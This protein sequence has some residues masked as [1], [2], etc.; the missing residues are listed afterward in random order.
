MRRFW[1]STSVFLSVFL[2]LCCAAESKSLADG[3]ANPFASAF[4]AEPTIVDILPDVAVSAMKPTR[5]Q[6]LRASDTDPFYVHRGGIRMIMKG[7]SKTAPLPQAV[8]AGWKDIKAGFAGQKSDGSFDAPRGEVL[9]AGF[10]LASAVV[11]L[12]LEREMGRR[13]A[14]EELKPAMAAAAKW[15]C[16]LDSRSDPAL[17]Q[18]HRYT[19]RYWVLATALKGTA[20]VTG[21][22]DLDR[23]ADGYARKALASQLS[24]GINP[25]AGGYDVGYQSTGLLSNAYYVLLS[26]PGNLRSRSMAALRNGLDWLETTV[27]AD[28]SI[29][30]GSSTRIGK[31][32]A[33]NG[34][35]KHIPYVTIGS[36]FAWGGATTGDRKYGDI[37][38]RIAAHIDV[39]RDRPSGA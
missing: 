39:V 8:A 5:R 14:G 16:S 17:T 2:L 1:R 29:S 37:A 13:S 12:E 32:S 15:L 19:H 27:T 10:L 25:E 6:S 4:S 18:F 31:E 26:K 33:R 23:C 11:S 24:N 3:I 38:R 28:G 34:E 9:G 30:L 20:K 21:D 36:A 7:L 35:L 22:Q